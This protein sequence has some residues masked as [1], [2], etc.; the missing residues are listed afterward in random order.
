MT[1]QSKC[2]ECNSDAVKVLEGAL[3]SMQKEHDE[4]LAAIIQSLSDLQIVAVASQVCFLSLK[5]L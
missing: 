5:I 3:F 1:F 2:P 4:K